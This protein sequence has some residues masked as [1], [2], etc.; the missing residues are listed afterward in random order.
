[1]ENKIKKNREL[2]IKE[3]IVQKYTPTILK[4]KNDSS[5]HSGHTEQLKN[6]DLSSS[7]NN[8][9]THFQVYIVSDF[10]KNMSKIERHQNVMNLLNEEFKSGLHALQ[11]K[12]L[13]TNELSN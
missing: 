3:L 6:L 13:S 9:E 12:I 10:F 5:S 1:M 4:I 11:L 7:D 8:A 2:R